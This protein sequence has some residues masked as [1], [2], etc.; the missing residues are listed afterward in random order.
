MRQ[1]RKALAGERQ[2]G[3]RRKQLLA[4][5]ESVRRAARPAWPLWTWSVAA[6]VLVAVLLVGPGRG[7]FGPGAPPPAQAAEEFAAADFP[8]VSESGGFIPVAFS[9]PLAAGE[10]VRV[11]REELD[12]VELAAMGI[13]APGTFGNCVDADIVLGEDGLP[14]AVR[15]LGYDEF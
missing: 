3:F 14:R 10:S 13:D 8:D 15:L 9:Q 11:V 4:E 12:G 7:P 6:A 1:L 2:P 5:F